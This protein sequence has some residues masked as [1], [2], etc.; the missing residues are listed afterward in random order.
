M[1]QWPDWLVAADSLLGMPFH[2]WTIQFLLVGCMVG[3]F[4]NVCIH[5]MPLDQSVFFP[6]SHCPKCGYRI[7]LTLN[8][9]VV[10]WFWL[11]GKCRGCKTPISPRY[12]IIEI[13]TGAVFVA[14][15][16]VFG[17]TMPGMA[18][19]AAVLMSILIGST[20][21][22]FEHIIIPDQF[23]IGGAIIGFLMSAFIPQMHGAASAAES[24]KWSGAGI[25]VGAGVV[26]VVL[27]GGKLLFGKERIR[28]GPGARVVFTETAM[29]LPNGEALPYDDLFYRRTDAVVFDATRLELPDRCY[30]NQRVRLELRREPPL[31]K[32]GEET[33]D[34]SE[35]THLEAVTE[36]I[37]CPREAMG[38]GDV[39]F[40]A[41]I[42]AF[43]GWKATLF[44]F[45]LSSV[46]GA[47]VGVS[48]IALGKKEWSG[49]L[50]FGPYIAIAAAVWLFGGSAWVSAWFGR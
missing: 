1:G 15:W 5:R 40:M 34:A 10:T 3:S 46:L 16:L 22:D 7:P 39:K 43:L 14:C 24:L 41:C 17:R 44:S 36:D 35:V 37:S 6:P 31:L 27:R 30:A 21:I 28:L 4:L 26:Y 29:V 49:R 23:T 19:A 48:L 38:L 11:R 8:I 20:V 12:V 33:L 32:I 42:G 18:M 2:F 45:A 47:V 25:V 9:P 50:P 13:L